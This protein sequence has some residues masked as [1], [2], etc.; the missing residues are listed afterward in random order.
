[1]PVALHYCQTYG[2]GEHFFSKY[3]VKKSI[4]TGCDKP[5]IRTVPSDLALKYDYGVRPPR[6]DFKDKNTYMEV[7]KPMKPK[8]I[9]RNTFMLCQ[10][11]SAVNEAAAFFKAGA[12]G[13]AANL[14]Q[15]WDIYKDPDD[16]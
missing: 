12:C 10:L 13:D 16:R 9:K 5:L 3:R 11:T 14:N 15:T 6:A 2:V 7:R 4:I 8:L 1:M